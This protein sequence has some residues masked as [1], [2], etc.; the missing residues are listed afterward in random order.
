MIKGLKVAA[1]T[2]V[3]TGIKQFAIWT[4]SN[5]VECYNKGMYNRV[6]LCACVAAFLIVSS[7]TRHIDEVTC[8]V[9]KYIHT[10]DG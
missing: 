9:C 1:K 7:Y 4:F 6:F 8:N 5:V 2:C 3:K 10:R